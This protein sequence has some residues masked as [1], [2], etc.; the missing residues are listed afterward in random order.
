MILVRMWGNSSFLVVLTSKMSKI[1]TYWIPL[2]FSI[3]FS[4]F[5]LINEKMLRWK[6]FLVLAVP[7]ASRHVFFTK[8]DDTVHEILSTKEMTLSSNFLVVIS[9]EM[10]CTIVNAFPTF[11]INIISRIICHYFLLVRCPDLL[12]KRMDESPICGN[13]FSRIFFV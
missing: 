11:I 2:H 13:N 1:E 7:A 10:P 4:N 5:I 12:Q 3:T 8:T 6:P 9:K